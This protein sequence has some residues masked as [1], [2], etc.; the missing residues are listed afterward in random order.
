MQRILKKK[1]WKTKDFRTFLE[2]YPAEANE[3]HK[4][5]LPENYQQTWR[6]NEGDSFKNL[7]LAL[8]TYIL[9]ADRED[10]EVIPQDGESI[11]QAFNRVFHSIEFDDV[12]KGPNMVNETWLLVSSYW[13]DDDYTTPDSTGEY[14]LPWPGK[15][16]FNSE[17]VAQL[18]VTIE[19]DPPTIDVEYDFHGRLKR[20]EPPASFNVFDGTDLMKSLEEFKKIDLSWPD[21]W[22]NVNLKDYKM[23]IEIIYS[24]NVA[25]M[26]FL[27]NITELPLE[28]LY[29][30]L[31]KHIYDTDVAGPGI[32]DDVRWK[33]IISIIPRVDEVYEKGIKFLS[34]KWSYY[35]K[36]REMDYKDFEWRRIPYKPKDGKYWVKLFP[37][38]ED[39]E[40]ASHFPFFAGLNG[41]NEG[42]WNIFEAEN[43]P[44]WTAFLG[45]KTINSKV[46]KNHIENVKNARQK[47]LQKEWAE[48]A[49]YRLSFDNVPMNDARVVKKK[50]K[51]LYQAY[52][53]AFS[54]Y[55]RVMSRRPRGLGERWI[56]IRSSWRTQEENTSGIFSAENKGTFQLP[57][58]SQMP[59]LNQPNDIVYLDV[60]VQNNTPAIEYKFSLF[61]RVLRDGGFGPMRSVRTN[62]IPDMTEIANYQGNEDLQRLLPEKGNVFWRTSFDWSNWPQNIDMK[63]YQTRVEFEFVR[64]NGAGP[65]ILPPDIPTT[66]LFDNIRESPFVSIIQHLSVF[67][68]DGALDNVETVTVKIQIEKTK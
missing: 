43:K 30:Y 66:L 17:G 32:S 21:D 59:L 57:W 20:L 9:R 7:Q 49:E 37:N 61:D 33:V 14:E 15:P 26:Y 58:P 62:F 51:D 4:H 64:R 60:V 47:R 31:S 56:S 25:E 13:E 16:R 34:E 67:V 5:I 35:T 23:M 46:I 10:H 39:L 42:D 63:N 3:L 28:K 18:N 27:D 41:K 45:V 68:D 54:A 12:P 8:S 24:S 19:Y 48:T 53:K 22:E 40:R 65:V 2:K 52:Q 29:E 1:F 38:I 6:N 55:L 11:R 44:F 36:D 50:G